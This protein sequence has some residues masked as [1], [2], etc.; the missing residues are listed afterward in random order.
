M[1]CPNLIGDTVMATPAFRALRL[2]YPEARITGVVKPQVA[3]VLD[4]SG[5][6]DDRVVFA[7]RAAAAEHR[8]WAAVRALRSRRAELAVLFPNSIRSALLCWLAGVPRRLGY[9]RGGRGFLLTDRLEPPRDSSG[10]L[11]IVPAVEYYLGLVRALGCPG[12]SVRTELFVTDEERAGAVRAWNRLGIPEGARV[13]C[14]NTGG[15]FGPAKN[16]PNG[17]FARL[18]RR[19][20]DEHDVWVLVLCGPQE[21]A[22]AAAIERLAKHD[23][24]RSLAH[25][26]PSVG[27][28]KAS[29]ARCVLLVTTDSGPRHFAGPLGVPVVTLF[30]PTHVG[31]TRTYHAN[32]LHLQQPV[33][34]GPCQKPI[35][36]EK[37]H[38]CMNELTPDVVYDAVR[39]LLDRHGAGVPGSGVPAA[40][41]V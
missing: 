1:V 16:W 4:G 7:P 32:A 27:L 5:W 23:R 37:H 36:P 3:P 21:R 33:P 2:R 28:T 31:W 29:I 30:G 17:H 19:L 41:S 26:V 39:R 14:L 22:N 6:F 24:V 18:A 34:C 15:A 11:R 40:G 10:R 38:R 25:E 9:V 12:F 13:V 8:T 20:V 35:C